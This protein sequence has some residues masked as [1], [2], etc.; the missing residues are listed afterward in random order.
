M[1][2]TDSQD[3]KWTIN[4]P[5]HRLHGQ[6]VEL[7]LVRDVVALVSVTEGIHSG[8]AVWINRWDLKARA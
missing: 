3:K 1:G 2:T 7:V 4:S 5:K 6:P 8:S